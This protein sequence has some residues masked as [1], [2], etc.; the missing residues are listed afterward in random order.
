MV[1]LTT[2]AKYNICK[3]NAKSNLNGKIIVGD[4][5]GIS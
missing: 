2:D 5:K 3:G 4:R 1:A